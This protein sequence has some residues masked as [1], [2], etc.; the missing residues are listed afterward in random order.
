MVSFLHD[1]LSQQK[2][3]TV[4]HTDCRDIQILLKHLD[5]GLFKNILLVIEPYEVREE[6]LN[7]ESTEHKVKVAFQN[8][9]PGF[10]LSA[11]E[12]A[13][14]IRLIKE[15]LDDNLD[16]MFEVVAI[17]DAGG[18]G[19]QSLHLLITVSGPASE[20]DVALS[21]VM[22]VFQ[23][24]ERDL[25]KELN[26]LDWEKFKNAALLIEPYDELPLE[27]E[28]PIEEEVEEAP[29][30]PMEEVE[31]VLPVQLNIQ[32]VPS[33]HKL[34][35]DDRESI[36]RFVEKLL[37]EN[38]DQLSLISVTYWNRRNL[39][40]SRELHPL[41]SLSFL[42]TVAGQAD[43]IDFALALIIELLLDNSE[44]LTMMLRSLQW[45]AFKNANISFEAFD[46]SA[47]F[48]ARVPTESSLHPVR[49]KFA[50]VKN[51]YSLS[52]DDRLS[53]IRFLTEL[54]REDLEEPFILIDIADAVYDSSQ[55]II[56]PRF[57]H[58]RRLDTLTL[59]VR[60]TVDSP[61][62]KSDDAPTSVIN[63]VQE[64]E[65][66]LAEYLRSLYPEAFRNVDVSAE[67]YDPW[68]KQVTLHP[69]QL[70]LENMPSNFRLSTGKK[71]SILLFIEDKVAE[72]LADAFELVEVTSA[73]SFLMAPGMET[74][75]TALR[76]GIDSVALREAT[77][78]PSSPPP[79]NFALP[80]EFRVSGP[81]FL[82]EVAESY[83]LE[84]I[85]DRLREIELY[86]RSL[87]DA[88]QVRTVQDLCIVTL[89]HLLSR[90]STSELNTPFIVYLRPEHESVDW[91]VVWQCKV[92]RPKL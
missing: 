48:V 24:H 53:I 15:L 41:L 40:S 65:Q 38:L 74:G 61:S 51:G 2:I 26:T 31:A 63:A 32:N 73:S 35:R 64:N 27:E 76:S 18:R 11:Y 4:L 70:I 23:E 7:K 91:D 80:L 67:S 62:D 25:K 83:L 60:I 58:R 28:V 8:V 33:D 43:V 72:S 50:N 81:T 56:S 13:A 46:S 54:V 55:G 68:Q 30:A 69:I 84:A 79:V 49:L 88:F 6:P 10:R 75:A 85:R 9:P 45:D 89:E 39:A 47:N 66:E 29:P 37:E 59:P 77:S 71:A 87:D 90:K 16:D 42:I 21:Y 52:R 78:P 92:Y 57:Q 44:E 82:S 19:D 12:K 1:R 14:I 3:T 17:A 36:L 34:S 22:D 86:V 20:S 5:W